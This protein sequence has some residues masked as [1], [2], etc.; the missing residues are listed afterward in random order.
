MCLQFSSPEHQ[1]SIYNAHVNSAIAKDFHYLYGN[2]AIQLRIACREAR[3]KQASYISITQHRSEVVKLALYHTCKYI[4]S[5][6]GVD[7]R[8]SGPLSVD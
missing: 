5:V 2:I 4:L 3:K 7:V 8:L 6:D 1:F